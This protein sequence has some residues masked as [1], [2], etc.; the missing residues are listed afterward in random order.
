MFLFL[1]KHQRN[2]WCLVPKLPVKSLN[3]PK[4]THHNKDQSAV[5]RLFQ[6]FTQYIVCVMDWWNNV[7]PQRLTGHQHDLCWQSPNNLWLSKEG[8][9]L[10][11]LA[12]VYPKHAGC[13]TC[14]SSSP[15]LHVNE[16]SESASLL[17]PFAGRDKLSP[18]MKSFHWVHGGTEPIYMHW[19]E[20]LCWRTW[21]NTLLGLKQQEVVVEMVVSQ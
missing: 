3:C 9:R 19:T 16:E 14:D 5:N 4:H 12:H 11:E 15:R 1:Q 7:C 13:C 2:S 21:H 18:L 20:P 10:W 17:I 6:M 8:P